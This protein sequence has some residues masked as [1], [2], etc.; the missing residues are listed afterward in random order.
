MKNMFLLLLKG[1]QGFISPYTMVNCRYLPSCS[2]YSYQAI[3]KFGVIK[4][5]L[6]TLRRLLRCRP[7][8]STGFDPVP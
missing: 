2:Q 7:F 6:L 3:E 5:A 8:G 1:Y 4:G